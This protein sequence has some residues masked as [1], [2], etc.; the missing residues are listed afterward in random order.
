[1][2]ARSKHAN[3]VVLDARDVRSGAVPS[4]R[5]KEKK[6]RYK[7]VNVGLLGTE[8]I[9]GTGRG[10]GNVWTEKNLYKM[11]RTSPDPYVQEREA[12]RRI[13]RKMHD[14]DL[15]IRG[16]NEFAVLKGAKGK[17]KM[18]MESSAVFSDDGMSGVLYSFESTESPEAHTTGTLELLVTKAEAKYEN[19]ILDKLVKTEYEFVDTSE[20]DSDSEF[21]LV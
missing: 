11:N 14:L 12:N 10:A 19:N 17:K 3:D 20:S 4:R 13:N 9:N 15:D 8:R 21:E 18:E 1:M 7:G 6:A 16:R 2:P 5:Q